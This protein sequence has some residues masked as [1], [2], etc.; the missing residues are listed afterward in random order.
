[1]HCSL[2]RPGLDNLNMTFSSCHGQIKS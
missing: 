1:V 2:Q